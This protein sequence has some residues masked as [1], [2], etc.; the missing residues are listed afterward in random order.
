MRHKRL[1]GRCADHHLRRTLRTD[2]EET[3]MHFLTVVKM[4]EQAHKY[5]GQLFDGQQQ[6]VAIARALLCARY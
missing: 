6:R 2:P 1:P 4:P 5:P 3:A